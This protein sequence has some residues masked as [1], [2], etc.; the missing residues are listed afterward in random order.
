V[1]TLKIILAI[2]FVGPGELIRP[3]AIPQL[4]DAKDSSSYRMPISNGAAS[5]EAISIST[6]NRADSQLARALNS[7]DAEHSEL[8]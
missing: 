6:P 7:A 1:P 4:C 5:C 8:T 3:I 2:L